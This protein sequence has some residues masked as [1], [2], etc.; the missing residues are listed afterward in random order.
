MTYTPVLL[1][2]VVVGNDHGA[3]YID[4]AN[5]KTIAS[6][7]LI[8]DAIYIRFTDLTGLKLADDGQS[9]CE[10][11]YMTTDDVLDEYVGAKLISVSILDAPDIPQTPDEG[12]YT[13][14]DDHEVLFLRIA[15]TK[16]D[17]TFASHNEHNGYY[18]GIFI[19]ASE[20]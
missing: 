2:K 16:G 15:T 10:N 19:T 4:A 13:S 14:T 6:V 12:G 9:C 7:A 20:F 1:T 18:G 11:R 17:I 3:E 5:G 8:E